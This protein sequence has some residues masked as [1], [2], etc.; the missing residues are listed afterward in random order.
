MMV[1][2]NS[3]HQQQHHYDDPTVRIYT[4]TNSTTATTTW[5]E[6]PVHHV[7]VEKKKKK[8]DSSDPHNPSKNNH[9]PS[10]NN[11]N[12][13]NS[14]DTCTTTTT[15][16]TTPTRK[17]DPFFVYPLQ[18]RVLSL[19]LPRHYPTSVQQP[20]YP[21]YAGY[22]FLASVAGSATMVLSTQVLL[23]TMFHAPV[24][25]AATAGAWNWILKD[26]LG[27]LGGILVA[28]MSGPSMDHHPKRYR[29]LAAVLLDV[30]AVLELAAPIFVVG[31][32]A[33]TEKDGSFGSLF[34]LL[35]LLP[36]DY[37]PVTY[38][39][40][41]MACAATILKNI[42]CLMA[43]AS[44]ATLH[45]S[46]CRVNVVVVDGGGGPFP[47]TQSNVDDDATAITTTPTRHGVPQQQQ[48]QQQ[49]TNTHN[50]LAD[51]TAK[52]AS[53]STAAGLLGTGLAIWYGSAGLPPESTWMVVLGC[54]AVHQSGTYWAVQSVALSH[55]NRPRLSMVLR[56]FVRHNNTTLSPPPPSSHSG[57]ETP[58]SSF[59]TTTTT[60]ADGTVLTPTQVA[61]REYVLPRWWC[62]PFSMNPNDDD[63]WLHIGGTDLPTIFPRGVSQFW[64]LHRACGNEEHYILNVDQQPPR[65]HLVF[66]QSATSTDVIRG[67]LHAHLLHQ[68]SLDANEGATERHRTDTDDDDV[69]S[70][71]STSRDSVQ[72]LFPPLLNHL[73]A[74]GWNTQ[75]VWVEEETKSCRL[76]IQ[77]MT[78][79]NGHHRNDAF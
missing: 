7:M 11:H 30:A 46:L 42:A 31:A 68:L 54:M 47:N 6:L 37:S 45:Q 64:Q 20:G 62:D 76:A 35:R 73:Q 15:T 65:I 27:Q 61:A 60:A 66:F 16:T 74:V 75:A 8:K 19:V 50:N 56:H 71:I 33:A 14:R 44:K 29:L 10:K 79:S 57:M 28:S 25:V 41:P 18:R 23:A 43:S 55:F 12:Y 21:R 9:N 2:S 13:I 69:V 36:P 5:N 38:I 70:N 53:Q 22:T 52:F 72:S 32:A 59:T 51:V 26:G 77:S 63:D 40:V 49:H 78:T 58:E 1:P 67:M 34:L 3:H 24:G 17:H 48:Q 4:A 39:V